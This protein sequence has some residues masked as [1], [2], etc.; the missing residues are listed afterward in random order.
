[1]VTSRCTS[2]GRVEATGL[3]RWMVSYSWCTW[4]SVQGRGDTDT[5]DWRKEQPAE[6]RGS[7]NPQLIKPEAARPLQPDV[8]IWWR[9]LGEHR[10]ME[11]EET[12]PD[13]VLCV[14]VLHRCLV[15]GNLIHLSQ[16]TLKAQGS[17]VTGLPDPAFSSPCYLESD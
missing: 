1:M 11:M 2:S 8:I 5:T 16:D 15:L 7:L 14:C 17:R 6:G 10:G 3:Q 12:A 4:K 9:S 13:L